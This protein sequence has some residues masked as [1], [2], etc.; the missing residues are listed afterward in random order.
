MTGPKAEHWKTAKA[1]KLLQIYHA[2]NTVYE[3][4]Q[5]RRPEWEPRPNVPI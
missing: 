4:A 2:R 3:S 5:A 1:R